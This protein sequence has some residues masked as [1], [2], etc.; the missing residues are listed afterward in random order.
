MI[1]DIFCFI[2]V[3]LLVFISFDSQIV[4]KAFFASYFFL[5]SCS[6]WSTMYLWVHISCGRFFLFLFVRA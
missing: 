4:L 6:N 2:L 5:L 3:L 1:P